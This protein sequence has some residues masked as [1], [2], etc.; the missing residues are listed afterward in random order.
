MSTIS[1]YSSRISTYF[2]NTILTISVLVS[3]TACKKFVAIDAPRN[4][5]ITEI[6]FQSDAAAIATVLGLYSRMNVTSLSL[7]NGGLSVYTGLSSDEIYNIGASTTYDPYLT[8]G[9]LSTTVTIRNRFW[10]AAYERIFHANSI[11]EGLS[12]SSNVSEK[13]KKQLLGETL[14]VRATHYF[15]LVNLFGDVPLVLSSDYR[16]TATL[17]RSAASNIY[18]QI[19]TDLIEAQELMATEYLSTNNS[20]TNVR[21]RPNK[22]AAIALLSRI[23]LYQKKWEKAEATASLLIGNEDQYALTTNLANVFLPTNNKEVI[24]QVIPVAANANTAEGNLF[25]PASGTTRPNF[26][27]TPSLL[28]AFEAEDRRKSNW[29]SVATVSGIPYTYPFKYKVRTGGSPYTEYNII[30]RL[31]EQYLIRAEARAQQNNLT[32]PESA[33]T[34]INTIR[35]RAGLPYISATTLED[36]LL[37]IERE[38]QVELFCEWGH[39]WLDLKRTGRVDEI[40]SVVKGTDWQTTD[41]LYPIPF[42]DIT[43]NPFLSQNPGYH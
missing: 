20:I 8:N 36:V 26:A 38:R 42:N 11:I 27:F 14:L 3:A 24:W 12:T 21:I 22:Y 5:V 41:Q 13:V 23:Y 6:V 2:W 39:R 18:D 10:E 31:A 32:G 40:L 16:V 34:D 7:T 4:E 43:N 19:I 17:P 35:S 9:L 33:E 15:Y 25:I 37:A 29:T 28:N 1:H 30:L